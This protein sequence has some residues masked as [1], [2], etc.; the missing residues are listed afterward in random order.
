[1]SLAKTEFFLGGVSPNGFHTHFG[2]EIAKNGNFTYILKGGAGTGKSSLMK[3][4]AKEFSEKDDV[5]VYYCSSDPNSLDAVYLKN[6]G[7]IIVDGTSP[8]VFDPV[9]PGVSQKII[10]LGDFWDDAQLAKNTV[11]IIEVIDENLR[12]HKRCKSFVCALS[13]LFSDTYSISVEALNYTK[14]DSFVR[15]LSHKII[16]KSTISDGATRF[17]QLSALTPHG[18]LSL[19]DTISSYKNVYTLTDSFYS[20]SDVFLREMATTFT[21][22]GFDVVVSECT[23]FPSKTYEHLLVPQLGVAF[24]SSNPMNEIEIP[25]S[26]PINFLRFYDKAFISEKKQRLSFNKKACDDLLAEASGALFKSKEVHDEIE[27][28]Y[29][30]AMDFVGVNSLVDKLIEEIK[31]EY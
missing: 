24:I 20:G 27:N 6:S 7:I 1:M 9:Y 22:K 23:L 28:F 2:N 31:R 15:R 19:L 12:W 13:S 30:N 14:L 5:V 3:R 26:K 25:S 4:V 11:E 21:S 10:N 8:H 16:P 18:Y 29:I 17:S